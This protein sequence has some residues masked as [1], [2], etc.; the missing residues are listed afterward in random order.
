[1]RIDEKF[2]IIA[3]LTAIRDYMLDVLTMTTMKIKKNKNN[4]FFLE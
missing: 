3:N 4:L 1:M 2:I